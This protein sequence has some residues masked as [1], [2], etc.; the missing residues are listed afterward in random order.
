MAEIQSPEC[1]RVRKSRALLSISHVSGYRMMK[2]KG[3]DVDTNENFP[4][5]RRPSNYYC[6]EDTTSLFHMQKD[7]FGLSN[8]FQSRDNMNNLRNGGPKLHHQTSRYS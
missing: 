5:C 8:N 7:F 3:V 2:S 1:M 4:G 6:S